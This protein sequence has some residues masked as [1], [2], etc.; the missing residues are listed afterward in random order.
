MASKG[1]CG[2]ATLNPILSPTQS[3]SLFF[4][5]FT[6]DTTLYLSAS[7][8]PTSILLFKHMADAL[9]Q[10]LTCAGLIKYLVTYVEV[11]VINL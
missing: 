4:F 1:H 5:F 6:S 2:L 7:A 11:S 8:M 3:F 10:A 9:G